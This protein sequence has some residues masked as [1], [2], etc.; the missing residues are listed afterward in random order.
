[1]RIAVFGLTLVRL[2][3]RQEA[4][5]HAEAVDAIARRLG[6]GS[7]LAW[8]EEER[9]HFLLE[10]LQRDDAID[11]GVPTGDARVDDVFATF[12][13]LAAIHPESL[14][15]CVITMA[16]QPS[17]VLAVHFLQ[18]VA[19]VSPPRRVVPLFETGR[20]LKAAGTAVDRLLS[21]G[22]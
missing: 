15:A 3:I 4:M 13:A 22:W 10:A 16:S 2:D 5:R 17:D 9:V 19:G 21:N 1:R 6:R 20:D 18:K 12:R 11:D 14:G 8:P 7:Y